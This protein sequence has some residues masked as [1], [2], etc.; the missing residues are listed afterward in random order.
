MNERYKVKGKRRNERYKVKNQ[1]R[2][3][4]TLYLPSAKRDQIYE[5]A[6]LFLKCKC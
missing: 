4:L 2:F 3:I 5:V 6:N 1:Y